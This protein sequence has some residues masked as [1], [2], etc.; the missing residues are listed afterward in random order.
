[1]YIIDGER[2]NVDV[3]HDMMIELDIKSNLVLSMRL[4]AGNCGVWNS[5]PLE[6]NEVHQEIGD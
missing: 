5:E 1:M 6:L 3:G 2:E 4:L